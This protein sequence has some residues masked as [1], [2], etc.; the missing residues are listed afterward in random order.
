MTTGGI[1]NLT[2]GVY[3]LTVTDVNN[4]KAIHTSTITEPS[5]LVITALSNFP[6]CDNTPTGAIT[7]DI[8]GGTPTYSVLW[9]N[10]TSGITATNLAVGLITATVTDN[11]GCVANYSGTVS[12]EK[13]LVTLIPQLLSPNGD[14]KNEPF[15]INTIS[16][17]PDNKLEIYNRWGN[18]VYS[19]EKYDNTFN[20]QPNVSNATGSG[21]LPA[22]TYFVVFNF[23]DGKT[24]PYKGYVEVKY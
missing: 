12:E 23:G 9:S 21:L 17:F 8:T 19:K 22:G 5:S 1:S 10:A 16:Y 18:M 24:P 7:L 3:S 6:S 11:N 2:A 13:C 15:Y 14:G 20:G 4:C